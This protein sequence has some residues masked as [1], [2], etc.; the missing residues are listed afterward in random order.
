MTPPSEPP[1][2]SAEPPP[3][4]P[5]E[6]AVSLT[7][8]PP[9]PP[10]C[11]ANPPPRPPVSL[12]GPPPEPPLEPPVS[13][14]GSP[15]EPPG[16][17]AEPPPEPPV[18]LPGP[19]PEPPGC[20]AEPPPEPPVSL[21][22][23]PPEPPGCPAEPPVS[24]PGPPP[25]PPGCPAEPPV[26]LTDSPLELSSLSTALAFPSVFLL[27]VA[28]SRSRVS[29]SICS[30]SRALLLVLGGEGKLS[31]LPS[32]SSWLLH[33]SV[34]GANL[35]VFRAAGRD[36]VSEV[37]CPLSGSDGVVA[38]ERF[39]LLEGTCLPAVEEAREVVDRVVFW[40]ND[41]NFIPLLSIL[42]LTKRRR[43]REPSAG[44]PQM[45]TGT[46]ES[47]SSVDPDTRQ[48]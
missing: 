16:C 21:P 11:P 12:A 3:E 47:M 18:S 13:L 17:S 19:P 23:P 39:R 1:D 37:S 24:L 9:E 14:P 28:F 2:C 48:S 31:P 42:P 36:S 15:P 45:T 40:L 26:S 20:S 46:L 4:P 44:G 27:F 29:S 8:P 25:E 43:P 5:S 34:A 6:P 32:D 33:L 7:G 30:A 38:R 35:T 22:G 41:L 10:G